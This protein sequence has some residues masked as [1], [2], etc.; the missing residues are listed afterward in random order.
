MG[1]TKSTDAF[2]GNTPLTPQATP[3]VAIDARFCHQQRITT[4]IHVKDSDLRQKLKF[5]DAT[6]GKVL[7]QTGN[8]STRLTTLFGALNEPIVTL[9]EL[10]CNMQSVL[11]GAPPPSPAHAQSVELFRIYVKIGKPTERS[12]EDTELCV[13]FPDATTGAHCKLVVDGKWQSRSV[14]FWLDRG[15]S[16]PK[17][18]VAKVYRPAK[19]M[20]KARQG[21][22]VLEIASNVDC[23]LLLLVCALLDDV[24]RRFR[25]EE[26]CRAINS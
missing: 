1:N 25:L 24:L 2:Y 17:E 22:Y 16:S 10:T 26:N 14:I 4:R 19:K 9:K 20:A 15:A 21:G 7:F 18:A 11:V 13:D 5:K 3:I 8:D 23:A 6:T 12:F